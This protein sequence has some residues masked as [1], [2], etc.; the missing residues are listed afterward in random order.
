MPE[1]LEDENDHVNVE[2]LGEENIIFVLTPPPT[3][4]MNTDTSQIRKLL[5]HT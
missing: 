1:V 5:S 4:L 2:N 3:S